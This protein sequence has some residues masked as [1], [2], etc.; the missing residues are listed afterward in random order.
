[1]GRNRTFQAAWNSGVLASALLLMND[2]SLKLLSL[3]RQTRALSRACASRE[4][5]EALQGLAKV[6]ER[7][8]RELEN[9]ELTQEPGRRAWLPIQWGRLSESTNA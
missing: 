7:Q 2:A 3:A 5:A 9:S 4:Q 6:Y 8:A 1:M